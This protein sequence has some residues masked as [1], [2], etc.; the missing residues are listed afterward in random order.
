M[1]SSGRWEERWRQRPPEEANNLNPAFCG[2]LIART[3][4]EYRGVQ[5][6]PLSLPLAY[7]VLPIALH[8]PTR[9]QLPGNASAA[10][11]AWVAEH[12]AALAGFPERVAR[13]VPITREALLLLL[14]HGAIRVESG[15]LALNARRI[16]LSAEPD[17]RTAD[18][19]E[20]RA[21]AGLLGRWFARQRQP[22]L[23]MQGLGVKP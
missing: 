11:S 1:T 7:L 13:L 2:E 17:R 15:C 10:F 9:D 18:T 5:K 12:G 21:A 14:Q 20:A 8:K 4:A 16:S 23:V 22:S 6:G 3:I 19:D